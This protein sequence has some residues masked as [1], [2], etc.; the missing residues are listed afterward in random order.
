MSN[1]ESQLGEL[2]PIQDEELE[3][4]LAWRNEPSVRQNMYTT[5]EITFEEHIAWWDRIKRSARDEYFMYEFAGSPM[6]IV[7]FNDINQHNRNSFWAFYASPNAATGSG[8]RM[9]VLAL[10]YA[11]RVMNL[12]K[13]C[14]EVLAFNKP[15]IK[16]HQKFGF[17]VEGILRDQYRRDGNFIDIYRLGMLNSEWEESRDSM[18]SKI[19]RFTK[20]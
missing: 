13:L 5:H 2:R 19:A 6:G 7:G 18:L 8:T 16:L 3:L 4:M 12:H 10:D 20:G 9:E 1:L 17:K 11:F 14:C 15:V